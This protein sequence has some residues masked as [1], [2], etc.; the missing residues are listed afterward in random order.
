VAP[1]SRVVLLWALALPS[2][3]RPTVLAPDRSLR[4]WRAEAAAPTGRRGN[5]L[6][7]GSNNTTLIAG[8]A[9]QLALKNA[10]ALQEARARQERARARVDEASQLENPQLRIRDIEL[11]GLAHAEPRLDLALRVPVPAPWTRDARG[12]RARLRLEEA[13]AER[14]DLERRVRAEV[15]K[16][17]ARLAMLDRRAAL[18]KRTVDLCAKYRELADRRVREGAA[19]ELDASLP[20]LRHAEALDRQHRLRLARAQTLSRLRLLTGVRPDRRVTFRTASADLDPDGSGAPDQQQLIRRALTQRRDL[21]SAAARVGVAEADAYIAR[22]QRWP[23]LRFAEVGYNIRPEPDPLNFQFYL[24]FDIPLLSWNRGA[25]AAREAQL[26]RRRVEERAQI[27]R[28]AQEVSDAAA[29][30]R[31]T[32][33]QLREARRTLLPALEAGSKA[34]KQAVAHGVIDPLRATIV[35][36]RR[37]RAQRRYLDTQLAH[38]EAVIDLE[39]A[40]GDAAGGD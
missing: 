17:Y 1:L 12:E 37:F 19:T 15:R 18:L 3:F 35:E 26:A 2:C 10:P 27:L 39:A 28:A 4:L 36:W 21:R 13:S 5:N 22:A 34:M 38:R 9:V 8:Q 24:A 33:A 31:E 7:K 32:G 20:K 16:L 23:W 11:D 29:R 6:G 40:V 14:D 30:V 25:I